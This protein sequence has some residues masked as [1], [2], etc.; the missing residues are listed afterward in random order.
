MQDIPRYV[1]PALTRNRR[2]YVKFL[3]DLE[4][5]GLVKFSVACQE[6]V[7]LF[8]V[9]KKSGQLRMILDARRTNA[10]FRN[11]PSR[12]PSDGGGPR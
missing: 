2:K 4:K 8:F 1:D 10:R 7:G 6:Q 5:R 3:N 12:E 9:K 11:P